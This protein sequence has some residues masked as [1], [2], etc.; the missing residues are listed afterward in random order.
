MQPNIPDLQ[1]GSLAH[2]DAH[3]VCRVLV[4][5][6]DV[7]Q[8]IQQELLA[9]GARHGR[10]EGHGRCSVVEAPVCRLRAGRAP[11]AVSDVSPYVVEVFVGCCALP[12]LGRTV[13]QLDPA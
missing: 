7:P 4:E 2:I 5:N 3:E 11:T 9:D 12:W 1:R 10:E 6:V 8:P 13:M